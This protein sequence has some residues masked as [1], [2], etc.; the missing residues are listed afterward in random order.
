MQGWITNI[1][2][3]SLHDGPGIRTTVFLKGCQLRCAWCH[4]PESIAPEAE[5]QCMAEHCIGCGNCVPVCAWGAIKLTPD[6]PV[7]DRERCGRCGRC[8]EVCATGALVKVG[9]RRSVADVLGQ[10]LKDRVFYEC[11]GGGMTVS[12]GEPLC[13][14][15]FAGALLAAGKEAGLHTALDTNL[16]G[17]WEQ[18][19]ALRRFVDLFLVD[20]KMWD[21][22]DHERWTGLRNEGLVENLRRLD[23]AGEALA[24]RIPVI[25]GIN[26][27]LSDMEEIGGFLAGLERLVSVELL[28]YHAL[29]V[30]KAKAM[31]S[32][33]GGEVW[34]APANETVGALES[35]LRERGAAV[36]SCLRR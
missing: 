5:I 33:V 1:Q 26:D 27:R 13:Q 21:G 35:V 14:G 24:V 34:A 19:E 31:G 11:S 3:F 28:P 8:A 20:L 36:R 17:P 29:G 12:G 30:A 23:A 22:A 7:I 15:E 10:V 4:N 32:D 25:A 16:L 2:H 6:G 18:V 9:E